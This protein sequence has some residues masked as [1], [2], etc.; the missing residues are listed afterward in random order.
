MKK[1]S[2]KKREMVYG[3]LFIS[4]WLIGFLI[5]TLY[6]IISSLYYS[7]C[8]YKV[9]SAPQFI[10]MENYAALFG[11]TVFVKALKNT[12]YMVCFGVPITTFIAVGVSV[13]MNNKSLKHTGIFRVLF[14]I[15]TLV[16]TV[17]AC[18]LWI[19]VMQP[20]TGIINR[21]LGYIGITGPGWLSSP[22]WSKPAFILMM[23]W[24]CGN[25]I[26]IYLAGLQD[27]PESLYE[28]ASI[29]GA[30]FLRQTISI[31][32][33]LLRSTILYNVVTLI[34]GVFQWFAEP[35]IITLGGPDN[36][37]MF[38]ALYLYQN[39]FTYFKMGYASAQAW[40]LLV[41]ALAIIIVLFKVFKFGESDY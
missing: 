35:Y 28:S 27:I 7:L 19:W 17:V 15:P 25:A 2:M 14:F 20:E 18:L 1:L 37:T 6:P 12:A 24:T 31:T 8:D 41:I 16:P 38:Y 26:I 32:I 22:R 4:P 13:M 33:P 29:D 30:S 34:I 3:L 5:F 9:I 23:I 39:A 40:I 21:L 10:G 11:D 36:S